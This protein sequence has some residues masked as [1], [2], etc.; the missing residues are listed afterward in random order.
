MYARLSAD[1]RD[2]RLK[3]AYWQ[4]KDFISLFGNPYFSAASLTD[5]GATFA[6]PKLLYFGAEYGRS[7]GKGFHFLVEVDY[8]QRLSDQLQGA[9]GLPISAS[10]GSGFSA[11]VCMRIN[12]SF[13]LKQF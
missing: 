2:F 8:F 3:G 5:P 7:L 6:N 9:D 10:S 11:S 1:V 4:A 12:P 13:L